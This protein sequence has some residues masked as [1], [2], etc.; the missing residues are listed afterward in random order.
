MLSTDS[1]LDTGQVGVVLCKS[2]CLF[3]GLRRQI[4]TIRTSNTQLEKALRTSVHHQADSRS[5]V[6]SLNPAPRSLNAVPQS[7]SYSSL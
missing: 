6:R 5:A 2:V 3:G 7:S 1:K 4:L